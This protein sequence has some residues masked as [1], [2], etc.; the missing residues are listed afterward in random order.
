MYIEHLFDYRVNRFYNF[1]DFAGIYNISL[2]DFMKYQSLLNT[3]SQSWLEII[4]MENIN[5]LG[6]HNNILPIVQSSKKVN[7][8]LCGIQIKKKNIE[9]IKSEEKW[10]NEFSEIQLNWKCIYTTSLKC[11]IDTT[12]RNFQYKYLMRLLGTNKLLFRCKII[13][14]SLCDFCSMNVESLKH[15][16]WECLLSSISIEAH[17]GFQ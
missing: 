12:L 13:P 5:E 14:S 15:L 2:N 6:N 8:L 4:R 1:N 10:A 17:N 7:K 16:F 3:I 11:T 9:Q